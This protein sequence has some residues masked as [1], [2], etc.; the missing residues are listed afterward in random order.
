MRLAGMSSFSH[1]SLAWR[2][3]DSSQ[4]FP[5]VLHGHAPI[6]FLKMNFWGWGVAEMVEYLPRKHK[7]LSSNPSTAKRKRTT[8]L[9]A[10]ILTLVLSPLTDKETE[11]RHS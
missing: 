6:W 1:N 2:G 9:S 8:G 7:T 3:R 10:L 11:A 5:N 4:D